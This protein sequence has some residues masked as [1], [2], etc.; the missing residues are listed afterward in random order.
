MK[1]IFIFIFTLVLFIFT[2]GRAKESITIF[3]IGDSTMADKD[4]GNENLERG[5]GQLLPLFLKGEIAVDNHAMN[6]RSSKSFIDE[7]RWDKVLEK[8]KKGDYV[9]IQF[10]HNDEKKAK[11][12]HT[13]PGSTFDDNLRRFVNETRAKGGIPVLFNSIVRR[14]F[15]PEGVTEHK[16]SYETEGDVLVDTHGKYLVSPCNVAEELN[17]PFVDMNKLTHDLVVL[18]GSEKSKNLFMWIPPGVYTFCPKGKIDNTHLNIYGAKVIAG[19]T[20]NEVTKAV[21]DLKKFVQSYDFMDDI[22]IA[23]YKD[24][25]TCAISYTYDD[26]LEEHYSLVFPEMEKRGLKGT[27]WV[28]GKCIDHEEENIDKHRVTWA[29]LKEISDAGHEISNHSWSHANLTKISMED[30]QN[31][32]RCN[33]SIILEKIKKPALS[34]CYPF[35]A[36]N[37]EV[38]KIA[39]KNRVGTRTYQMALGTNSTPEKLTDWLNG[40]RRKKEWGIAMIHGI[41]EGYDA[42]TSPYIL[43]EHFDDVCKQEKNI[44]V[45]TFSEVVSYIKERDN[46]DLVIEEKSDIIRIVP[47]PALNSELFAGYLTLVVAKSNIQHVAVKQNGTDLPT[48]I[49]PDKVV[50]DFNPYGGEIQMNITYNK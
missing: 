43:W 40:L 45:G 24:D 17:V 8:M 6:G 7:G 13:V 46:T 34:F 21:P 4:T 31:E 42:F 36:Y 39:S 15:P 50:F 41:S 26:G 32:I 2:S 33:D 16:G 30:V 11:E 49:L 19:I 35:N 48:K 9:F 12:L 25:K 27:F 10:G 44:W 5:W 14:N 38:L 47:H 29:Q 23:R 20:A 18:L 37:N 3:M 1:Q 22:Y 28:W